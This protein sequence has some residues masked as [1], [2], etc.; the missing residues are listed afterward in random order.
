MSYCGLYTQT[1]I[2]HPASTDVSIHSTVLW[3]AG[4]STLAVNDSSQK[5]TRPLFY[6]YFHTV[7]ISLFDRDCQLF[8]FYSY[9]YKQYINLLAKLIKA[10]KHVLSFWH[11]KRS[12]SITVT[13]V[14]LQLLNEGTTM[15]DPECSTQ[16]GCDT[17][18]NPLGSFSLRTSRQYSIMPVVCRSFMVQCVIWS[19]T[20]WNGCKREVKQAVHGLGSTEQ[21]W[22][23]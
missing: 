6:G 18:R 9:T 22:S 3:L 15:W 2:P 7:Y 17:C 5:G 12:F 23:C 4:L 11:L 10:Q 1:W 19:R 20:I 14:D 16:R 8:L 13:L 21:P